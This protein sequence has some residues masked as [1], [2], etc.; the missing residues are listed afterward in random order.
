ML[1]TLHDHRHC[2]WRADRAP[3]LT[4]APGDA[5]ALSALDASHGHF[6]PGDGDERVASLDQSRVNPVTGPIAVDGA[7][8][9]DALVVTIEDLSTADWGWTANIPGFGLLADE[10]PEPAFR[11]W[12]LD[13]ARG[14]ARFPGGRAWAPARPF[15]GTLGVSPG[16]PGVHPIIPPWRTGGNLDCRDLAAGA[17]IILPVEVGGAL[18]SAGDGHIAQGDGE[19]C[20]T[21]LETA[22]QLTVRVDLK[23]GAA[24]RA[25]VIEAPARAMPAPEP[26]LTTTGVGPDFLAA[27][28]D[29]VREMIDQLCARRGLSPE[30]AYLLCSVCGE[31]RAAQLVDAPNWTAAFSFPLSRL[32]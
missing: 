4:L 6:D 14:I 30:D 12:T 32:D 2:D 19:V 26:R 20:G 21:A 28:R 3:A 9:G 25:P 24:P 29:A 8:P 16:A 13:R 22:T 15:M 23:P 11:A 27:A 7:A 5:A 10:F 17:R 18:L 31:M 1:K